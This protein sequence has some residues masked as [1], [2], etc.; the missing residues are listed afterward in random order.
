MTRAGA[1]GQSF[2]LKHLHEGRPAEAL[3]E[4]EKAMAALP[5]DPEPVLDRA[6][7]H[8]AER[9]WEAAFADVVRALELDKVALVLDDSVVDDT[10]FSTLV[11]WASEIAGRDAA[12]AVKLIERYAPLQ[13]SGTHHDEATTWKNR[14]QG[15]VETWVKP[16]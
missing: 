13:P 14:F 11:G 15:R 5:D 4:A 7:V 9:R 2:A 16:H 1:Y 3:V 12:A 10:V 6:Q 8:L